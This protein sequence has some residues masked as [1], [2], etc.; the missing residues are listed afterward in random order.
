MSQLPEPQA[1]RRVRSRPRTVKEPEGGIPPLISTREDLR[2][3]AD[4]LASS[5]EAAALDTERAGGH[6]YGN[7][8]Y[9]VQVRK[10]GVGTFILDTGALRDLSSLQDVLG[11]TWIFHAA[12]QDILGLKS[13]N[14][15][16]HAIFDTEIAARLV[17]H[18][19]FS[20]GA[21]TESVLDT[22]LLKSHQNE[23]WSRRPIPAD[24][25]RYAALDVEFLPD[26][27]ERLASELRRLGREE[28]AAQEFNHLLTH[29]LVPREATWRDTK[30]LGKITTPR[31]MAVARELWEARDRVG[32]E[33]DVAPGRIL[34]AAAIVEASLALPKSR[35]DL[36]KINGF[37]KPSAREHFSTWEAAIAKARSLPDKALPT[38][39]VE[40]DHSAPPPARMW[41]KVDSEAWS[42][43]Q[44]I[45][46]VVAGV[47]E[48]MGV[49]PDVVLEP[50][51][52][53]EVTWRPPTEGL[54]LDERMEQSGARPWQRQVVSDQLQAMPQAARR[55]G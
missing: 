10:S 12:D 43:L 55:L 54:T 53:R 32:Q 51:V 16:P 50:R 39:R 36:R 49:L 40:P 31:G 19:R 20:L 22:K 11:D 28:F 47:A 23:D 1:S 21:L 45:R 37:Q 44:T 24:W 9:L 4:L 34:P 14:L 18:T 48:R 41:R 42:R 6:R 2:R 25:L 38:V 5:K 35:T 27:H 30:G 29:P 33:T 17:G 46:E 52:Q 3:S 15:R 7:D 26:L 13:L 8:T